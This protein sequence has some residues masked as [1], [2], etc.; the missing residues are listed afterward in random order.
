MLLSKLSMT[1]LTWFLFLFIVGMI[2]Y[3]ARERKASTFTKGLEVK[4][5][6]L[7]GG[8]KLIS[9][10]DV[11]QAIVVAFGN[12]IGNME[13]AQLEVERMERELESDPFVKNADVYID[14]NDVLHV[15]IDQRQPIMR[16]LDAGGNNYY[17]DQAGKRMPASRQFAARVMVV[18]GHLAA[19][20]PEFAQ[21]RKNT[22]K[23][24][25]NLTKKIQEDEFLSGFIQQIHVNNLGEFVLV[26]LIG[27]QIIELGAAR[28]LDDKFERLKIFY[29]HGMPYEGWRKYRA[30]VLKYSGQV[31]CRR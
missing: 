3:L 14:Q 19:Y 28:R 20:T 25:F 13:L 17:L 10:R 24:A 22:L 2:W 11:R 26:P 21:K 9:E 31:V 8:D 30:I 15:R 1:R 27:D 5:N 12:D 6:P 4:V 7:P 18:T 29:Q 16:V 23:D